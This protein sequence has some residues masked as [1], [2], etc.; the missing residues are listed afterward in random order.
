MNAPI[1]STTDLRNALRAAQEQREL[2]CATLENLAGIPEGHLSKLLT[3]SRNF[4]PM[5]FDPLLGALGK[6]LVLVDDAEA[7]ARVSGRWRK[8]KRVQSIRRQATLPVLADA[9]KLLAQMS[10]LSMA[11]SMNTEMQETAIS[12]PQNRNSEYMKSLGKLGGKRRMKTMGKRARQRIASHA[13][14]ARWSRR[15]AG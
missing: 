7:I 6:A 2:S 3:G 13:A 10:A 4:G 1:R 9:D 8:R 15:Q 14:R 11:L 12:Q 5:T